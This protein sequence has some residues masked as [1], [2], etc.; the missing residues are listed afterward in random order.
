MA[1]QQTRGL[2]RGTGL[3]EGDLLAARALGRAG[4]DLGDRR[5]ARGFGRVRVGDGQAAGDA[6]PGAARA[7][8]RRGADAGGRARGARG[9]PPPP[10]ARALPGRGARDVVGPGARGGGGARAR[11]LAGA[12]GADRAQARQPHARPA[13]GPDPDRRRRD[14]GARTRA[15]ADLGDGEAGTF[16]RVSDSDPEMLR[17][18]SSRGIDRGARD[19]GGGPRALR[20]PAHGARRRSRARPGRPAGAGH[21]GRRPG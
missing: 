18:L 8:P 1:V 11:D 5:A 2:R 19:R 20:R 9:H 15:L 13:R 3:R 10:P 17:Y 6:R 21:A 16:T 7:L 12:V 4:L 14:R